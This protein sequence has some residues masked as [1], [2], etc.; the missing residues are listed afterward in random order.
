MVDKK[1]NPVIGGNVLLLVAI[2]CN[3]IN[4]VQHLPLVRFLNIQFVD[5][6]KFEHEL[7]WKCSH[8]TCCGLPLGTFGRRLNLELVRIL[9]LQLILILYYNFYYYQFT[10]VRGT[11]LKINFNGVSCFKLFKN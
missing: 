10:G 3:K 11:F 9:Y 6:K 5:L 1:F 4:E 2:S 7:L 8:L